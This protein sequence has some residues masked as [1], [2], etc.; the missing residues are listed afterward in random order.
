M[1]CTLEEVKK[2]SPEKK[3]RFFFKKRRT[4]DTCETTLPPPEVGLVIDGRTLNVIFQGGLEDKFLELTKYCRSVLCC[5]ATPLQKS[6]VV[7]LVRDKLNVM[8][9]SIGKLSPS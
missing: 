2:F 6:M 8:T 4:E 3:K 7:K 9:L 1:D 5:R